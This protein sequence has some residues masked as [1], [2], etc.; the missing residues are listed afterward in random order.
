MNMMDNYDDGDNDTKMMLMMMYNDI[1][2]NED[3][4]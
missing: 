3:Y 2:A 1:D 4:G